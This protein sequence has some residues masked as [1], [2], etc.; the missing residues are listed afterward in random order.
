[1][2]VV[3]PR[4]NANCGSRAANSCSEAIEKRA[5]FSV[6]FGQTAISEVSCDENPVDLLVQETIAKGTRVFYDLVSNISMN[7][8]EFARLLTEMNIR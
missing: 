5:S 2:D 6:F 1:M 3:I 7:K 4:Y 8:D